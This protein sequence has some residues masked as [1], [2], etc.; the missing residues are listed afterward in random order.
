MKVVLLKEKN[1]GLAR[2]RPAGSEIDL[3]PTTAAEWIASGE[4]RLSE[5]ALM[6]KAAAQ[7]VIIS[8]PATDKGGDLAT[9][10]K[11]KS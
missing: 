11:A 1:I 4:A 5:T 9:E 3:D 6:E 10:A 2:P 7:K 8:K